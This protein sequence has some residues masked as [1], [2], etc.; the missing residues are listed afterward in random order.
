MFEVSVEE[1]PTAVLCTVDPPIKDTFQC[2][3]ILP[4]PFLS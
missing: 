1:L 4:Q 3:Y 2:L